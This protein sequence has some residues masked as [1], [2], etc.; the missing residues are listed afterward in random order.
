VHASPGLSLSV[1]ALP[2]VPGP[3][4]HPGLEQLETRFIQVHPAL[5]DPTKPVK[6]KN[7]DRAVLLIHGYWLQLSKDKVGKAKFKD[8]QAAGSHLVSALAQES[9]V[10]AFA[11]GQCV[12]IEEIAQHPS[13]AAAVAQLK[14][15][16]YK[17]IVLVGHSAGGLVARYFVEDF[18]KSGVTKVVQ[19]CTPNGGCTYAEIKWTPRI[20]RPFLNSLTKAGRE[21]CLRERAGKKIPAGVQFVCIV[22]LEDALVPCSCQWTEDLQDQGVP[23]VRLPVGHRL[24]VRK[25]S[26][27]KKIAQVVRG[28]YPRWD[29][30]A[31]AAARKLLFKPKK[32]HL[33]SPLPSLRRGTHGSAP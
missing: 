18:P 5:V 2:L 31:V 14:K 30:E 24:S 27:V 25:A 33:A 6:S 15:L 4:E 3:A 7:H 29:A 19:V 17:D 1:I 9:D 11:Y 23:V 8:W 22:T 26:E 12:G 16:G 32:P 21:Q 28:D 10:F 13:L 20:Q